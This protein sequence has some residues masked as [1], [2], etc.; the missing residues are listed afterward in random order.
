MLVSIYLRMYNPIDMMADIEKGQ[1][2]K[3]HTYI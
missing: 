1:R 2:T 3:V